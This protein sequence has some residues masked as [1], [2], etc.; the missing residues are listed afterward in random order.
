MNLIDSLQLI[1]R[2]LVTETD[3]VNATIQEIFSLC[4]KYNIGA[5]IGNDGAYESGP[6]IHSL[7]I[8]RK[9]I[10][11]AEEFIQFV[12]E[13][14]P[15]LDMYQGIMPFTFMEM[16]LKYTVKGQQLP[17]QWVTYY[18]L[19]ADKP[20]SRSLDSGDLP[21]HILK[22]KHQKRLTKESLTSTKGEYFIFNPIHNNGG[23]DGVSDAVQSAGGRTDTQQAAAGS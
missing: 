2:I 19:I 7:Y 13:L 1:N 5:M 18:D 8:K 23:T 20:V 6:Y 10:I 11:Q 3:N 15:F 12:I 16:N 9:Q 21:I 17:A 22:P 4:D 14:T